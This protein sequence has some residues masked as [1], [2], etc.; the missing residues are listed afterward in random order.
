MKHQRLTAFLNYISQNEKKWRILHRTDAH[1]T[2]KIVYVHVAVTESI[3][4]NTLL[5]GPWLVT[6][7]LNYTF[8][9]TK[10]TQTVALS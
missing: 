10:H 1:V 9:L 4:L 2:R 7:T 8:H 5:T 3:Q 6:G